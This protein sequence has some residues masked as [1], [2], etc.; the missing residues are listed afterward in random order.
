MQTINVM[1]VTTG[2]AD[3][4]LLLPLVREL[5]R[6]PHFNTQVAATGTHLSERHGMTVNLVE[7]TE[8]V[9]LTD[10][11]EMT[12]AADTEHDICTAVSKGLSGFS[13]VYQEHAPDLVVVLGDRYELWSVC[14]AA[15]LHRIPIAHLHG[16]EATFGI[17]DD[18]IRHSVTKM[19]AL[20]F[21]SLEA[22]A[23]RIIQMGEDPQRVFTVGA[24]GLDNILHAEHMTLEELNAFTGVDFNQP[25]ALMTYH[26]VTL[27]DYGSGEQQVKEILEAIQDSGVT[28][29]MT[30]PNADTSGD[31]IFQQLQRYADQHPE[32]FRL[33]KNLGQKAYL[34]AMKYAAFMIGNSS[35]GIIEGASFHLPVVNIGDRQA[36]RVK[37]ANVIDCPCEKQ[38]ITAAINTARS[39][40]FRTGIEHLESPYGDG[41]TAERIAGILSTIDLSDKTPYLKKGFRDIEFG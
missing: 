9:I 17:I 22:Y 16:G 24:I 39:D 33:V 14:I 13:R 20:H 19:S 34:T 2:R 7:Q 35:S 25:V 11:V 21:A 1:T 30:M 37:P 3:F 18:P 38:A 4:G 32:Q 8:G 15:V 40:A 23:R 12:P 26:P 28:V 41:H 29:I 36:G 31:T 5:G 27:D 6:V 10:R